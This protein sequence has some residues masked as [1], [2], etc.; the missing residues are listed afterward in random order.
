LLI[1]GDNIFYGQT[2]DSSSVLQTTTGATVFGYY[3]NDPERFGVVDFDETGK[4]LSIE[5]NQLSQS[6][7]AVQVYISMT[8]MLLKLQ[9]ILNLHT[10]VS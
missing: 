1:L 9:K 10:V 2:L 6:N 8:I 3:V 7:Y 4:A 5:E